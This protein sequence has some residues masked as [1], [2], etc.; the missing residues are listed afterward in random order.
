[1]IESSAPPSTYRIA[2]RSTERKYIVSGIG[3]QIKPLR[4][5]SFYFDALMASSTWWV[6]LSGN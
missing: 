5:L 2:W 4:G 3:R 6:V 1:M